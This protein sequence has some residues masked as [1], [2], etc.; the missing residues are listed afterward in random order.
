MAWVFF[1]KQSIKTKFMTYFSSS[2]LLSD[3]DSCF[4]LYCFLLSDLDFY[5]YN[6]FEKEYCISLKW[7]QYK[8]F[9]LLFV[10]H[11]TYVL[12]RRLVCEIWQAFTF[13]G[14]A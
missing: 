1:S 7:I 13:D 8:N 9:H 3:E 4:F 12:D 6:E 5:K 10:K 11:Y 2:L 14:T